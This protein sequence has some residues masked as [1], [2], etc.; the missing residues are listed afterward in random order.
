MERQR[1]LDV[2]PVDESIELAVRVAVMSPS[3][4]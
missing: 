4:A 2:A 1:L 3:T